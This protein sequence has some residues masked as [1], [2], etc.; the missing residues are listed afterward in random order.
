M[1][2]SDKRVVGLD[3]ARGALEPLGR[4]RSRWQGSTKVA[5]PWT[6]HG[7]FA[8]TR[9]AR[10]AQRLSWARMHCPESPPE[11]S[12]AVHDEGSRTTDDAMAQAT[13]ASKHARTHARRRG[14]S[15]LSRRRRLV[16]VIRLRGSRRGGG[17]PGFGRGRGRS[18]G[19][20]MPEQQRQRA[21][22]CC[23]RASLEESQRVPRLHRR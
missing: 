1:V 3:Q 16:V 15:P 4:G 20:R 18:G 23:D 7:P 11:E 13:S 10:E 17:A 19:A 2:Y 14:F 5:F 8:V 6:D 21:R 22:G 12:M 9:Q